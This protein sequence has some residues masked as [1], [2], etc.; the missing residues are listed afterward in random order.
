MIDEKNGEE[1]RAVFRILGGEKRAGNRNLEIPT[2]SLLFGERRKGTY[3]LG[4]SRERE[5]QQTGKF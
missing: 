1:K 4:W 2:T 3:D 5:K